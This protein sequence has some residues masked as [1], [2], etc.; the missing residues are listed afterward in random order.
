V[1]TT[2]GN[3]TVQLT[4]SGCYNVDVTGKNIDIV[5][6]VNRLNEEGLTIW[7]NPAVD[8][9]R[10]SGTENLSSAVFK[11]FNVAGQQVLTGQVVNNQ[12]NLSQ[13]PQGLYL[14]QVNTANNKQYIVR[15][16]K[17]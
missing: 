5:N 8:F 11:M 2:P 4:A 14:L 10:I 7:P 3:Y 9:V 1:Y 15:V 16:N 17:R 6:S 13:V 12:I